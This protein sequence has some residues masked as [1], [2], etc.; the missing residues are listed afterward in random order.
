[1]D[2]MT[3]NVSI[4]DIEVATIHLLLMEE[5]IVMET[6]KNRKNA[7]NVGEYGY[8]LSTRDGVNGHIGQ[9]VVQVQVKG[10]G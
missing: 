9:A 7:L 2:L 6:L 8:L 4:Q 1:M 5:I 10:I 3:S